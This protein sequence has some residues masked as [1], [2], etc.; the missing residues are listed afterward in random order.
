[1][2]LERKQEE[3]LVHENN[4]TSRASQPPIVRDDEK[5][6]RINT[7]H[8]TQDTRHKAQD[9]RHK[10]QDTRHKTNMTYKH[11]RTL[12]LMEKDEKRRL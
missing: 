5:Y 4:A 6:K 11:L 3:K 9:T 12:R 10:A 2:E 1:M 8:K 7:R